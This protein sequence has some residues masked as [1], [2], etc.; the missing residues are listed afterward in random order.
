MKLGKAVGMSQ[1]LNTSDYSN[2]EKKGCSIATTQ[3]APP[4]FTAQGSL[5]GHVKSIPG[6]GT[7]AAKTMKNAPFKRPDKMK[8]ATNT[9]GRSINNYSGQKRI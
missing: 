3:K 5:V 8:P 9:F 7:P 1:R 6:M 2:T 4:G